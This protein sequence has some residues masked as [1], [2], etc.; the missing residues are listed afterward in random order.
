ML[1]RPT[2]PRQKLDFHALVKVRPGPCSPG[3]VHPPAIWAQPA[4]DV[5]LESFWVDCVCVSPE[6][7]LKGLV[8]VALAECVSGFQIPSHLYKLIPR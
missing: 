2:Y 8:L 5:L 3:G 4:I 7:G 1:P 6:E